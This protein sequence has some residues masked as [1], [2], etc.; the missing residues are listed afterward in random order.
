MSKAHMLIERSNMVL[1]GAASV[2]FPFSVLREGQKTMMHSCYE[3]MSSKERIFVQAPTGIGKTISA[4]Y[5][6]V[7]FL[8]NGRCDKIFY[9]TAKN[10]TQKEAYRAAGKLFEC[11]ALL[12][13]VILSSKEASCISP[14]K[15]EADFQCSSPPTEG[16]AC[17]RI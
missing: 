17:V 1:P 14:L 15:A 9:L 6:S 8:G 12:R 10:S 7:K 16:W 13:T 3:A 4:L 5:S 2:K 11:G